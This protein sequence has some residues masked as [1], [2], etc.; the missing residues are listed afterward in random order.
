MS[1]TPFFLCSFL[2]GRQHCHTRIWTCSSAG[3]T[4]WL[5]LGPPKRGVIKQAYESRVPPFFGVDM[6]INGQ[7]WGLTARH[8][9]TP[10]AGWFMMEN[11][12]KSNLEM[13][14]DW[15]YPYFRKP[16][17]G[18]FL[19]C[20]PKTTGLE[21]GFTWSAWTY[22]G[23]WRLNCR[24]AI[25]GWVG[26]PP[27]LRKSPDGKAKVFPQPLRRCLWPLADLFCW[28]CSYNRLSICVLGKEKG[29]T[30]L[31]FVF[32]CALAAKHLPLLCKLLLLILP[33]PHRL[34]IA[35]QTT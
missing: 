33:E 4:G 29:T 3:P 15:G 27:D 20:F 17:Y 31:W 9:D 19:T 23:D 16:P 22:D 10:T 24:I 5:F 32:D 11:P 1:G 34:H 6:I 2:P 8:G 25:V 21:V 12:W 14:G 26:V 35:T 13:D 7:K 18:W 28:N 30:N